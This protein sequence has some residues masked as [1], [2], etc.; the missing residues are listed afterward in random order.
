[1]A[2]GRLSEESADLR[3]LVKNCILDRIDFIRL[4]GF[5][6]VKNCH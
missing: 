6:R 2:A 1:M 5:V 3:F 4:K